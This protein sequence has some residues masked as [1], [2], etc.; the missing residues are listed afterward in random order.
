MFK[1][2]RLGGAFRSFEFGNQ[3]GMKMGLERSLFVSP[4][5]LMC[6][7]THNNDRNKGN[8]LTPTAAMVL[9]A[10]C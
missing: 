7:Y 9:L 8:H 6:V 5:Y 2:D 1:F 3:E 10:L 4:A